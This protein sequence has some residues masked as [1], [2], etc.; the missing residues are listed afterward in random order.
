[1]IWI[2]YDNQVILR[3]P[4]YTA[5]PITPS[6]SGYDFAPGMSLYIDNIGVD[7]SSID[8][9]LP[10]EALVEFNPYSTLLGTFSVYSVAF[11]PDDWKDIYEFQAALNGRVVSITDENGAY[12][13]TRPRVELTKWKPTPSVA[14]Y[15]SFQTMSTPIVDPILQAIS[16][17]QCL[18]TPDLFSSAKHCDP[19][20]L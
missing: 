5:M 20:R 19:T 17:E 14:P 8:D 15:Q 13:P 18:K 9:N 10:Y 3:P 2:V 11:N 16:Q 6:T 7:P 12:H 1:M 4:F